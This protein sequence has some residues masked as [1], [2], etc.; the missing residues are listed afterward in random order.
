MAD[1]T[2]QDLIYRKQGATEFVVASSGILNVES[3]GEL[4][5]NSGGTLDVTGTVSVNSGGVVAIDD[6]GYLTMPVASDDSS[7][8]LANIE[9]AV[10]GERRMC[11]KC[12]KIWTNKHLRICPECGC[13]SREVPIETREEVED[14]DKP[15]YRQ[16]TPIAG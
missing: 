1:V 5:V 10:L 4:D 7:A 16:C 11:P 6:G 13:G 8:S 14:G 3:G 15:G 9:K 2:Y 12:E